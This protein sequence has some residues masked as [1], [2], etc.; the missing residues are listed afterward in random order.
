[1]RAM[2]VQNAVGIYPYTPPISHLYGLEEALNVFDEE[3]LPN[4]YA[5][6]HYLASGVR[7]AVHAWGL[8]LCAVRPELY[9]DTVSTVM[10]PEGHSAST[11]I[12][13]AFRR[14]ELSLGGG[15]GELGGKAFRIGHLGDLNALMVSGALAGIEMALNDSGVPVEPGTGVGAAMKYWRDNAPNA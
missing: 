15:L 12:D 2:R 10:T 8:K 11:V 5:R 6:H 13:I 14:Y 7:A 3:G 1:M 4:V 9:S